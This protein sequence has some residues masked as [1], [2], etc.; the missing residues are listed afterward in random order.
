MN[1]FGVLDPA[2]GEGYYHTQLKTKNFFNRHHITLELSF[3]VFINLLGM[4][5]SHIMVRRS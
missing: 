4:A 1:W 5:S 3:I 2:E